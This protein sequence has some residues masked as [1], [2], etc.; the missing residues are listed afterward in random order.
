VLH[1]IGMGFGTSDIA[2]K[3]SRSV[4]T[5]ESHRANIKQKLDLKSGNE[6]TRYAYSLTTQSPKI[7]FD[8]Q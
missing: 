3:L 8:G 2:H 4:K 1:L 5:I 7:D 6:L